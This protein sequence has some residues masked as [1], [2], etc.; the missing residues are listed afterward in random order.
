MNDEFL[1]VQELANRLK[2]PISWVYARTRERGKNTIPVLR[3]GKYLRF[4]EAEVI[5]WLQ[6]RQ[7]RD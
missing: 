3:A 4:H 6:D 7:E 1:T 2:V 5:R